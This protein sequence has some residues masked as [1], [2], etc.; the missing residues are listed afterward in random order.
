MW[1]SQKSGVT[2]P[3]TETVRSVSSQS[4]LRFII[5][6]VIAAIP[7]FLEGFDN[8]LFSFGAPYIVKNVHGTVALLG[9]VASGYAIGISVFS[10]L[11]GYLFDRISVKFT[12]MASVALF[13][14]FTVLTGYVNNPVELFAVRMGVGLGVGVFQPAGHAL[15]G[16]IFF[17]TRGR[18]LG[19]NSA[20]F[21]FGLFVGPFLI[22]PFLPLYREPF[23]I[24]GAAA[25]ISLILFYLFVPNRFKVLER[26][27]LHLSGIF[28]R[29]VIILSV[30]IFLFGITLFGFLGYYSNYLLTI[31]R[32]PTGTSAAIY[33]MGGLG[34]MLCAFPIGYLADKVGRKRGL[35]LT[36]A[37]ILIGSVG[38]FVVA[39]AVVPLFVLT[40]LFG[41]GWGIFVGLTVGLAQ[42]STDDSIVGSVTG[43][44]FLVFNFGGFFGGPIF[45]LFIPAGYAEAGLITLGVS[46]A[47]SFGLT[48]LTRPVLKS[49][50]TTL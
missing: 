11:G 14:G 23:I 39:R 4:T 21:G 8:N 31:L 12:V 38:M 5:I 19:I 40:F 48:L 41:A 49:N 27:K 6:L 42:D 33:S 37:L 13:T 43:W 22:R 46:S 2:I 15:L 25:V 18:G 34:G 24:S 17:E 10:M 50:I 7:A 26:R 3:A 44:I 30:A 32:I 45:A 9:S 1:R 47:I 28:N 36:A 16:D 20:F 35:V 29:N